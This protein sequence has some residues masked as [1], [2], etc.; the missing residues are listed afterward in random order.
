MAAL[1]FDLLFKTVKPLRLAYVGRTKVANPLITCP[2]GQEAHKTEKETL[3][4]QNYE[5]CR[6]LQVN[7]ANYSSPDKVESQNL[8]IITLTVP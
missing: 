3:R 4:L 6:K 7:T 5:N 1:N 2:Q 8:K